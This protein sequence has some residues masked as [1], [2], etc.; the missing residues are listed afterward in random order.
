MC[1]S[2]RESVFL[3]HLIGQLFL[4]P[5][6]ARAPAGAQQVAVNMAQDSDAPKP[7]DK[8]KGKAVDESKDEKPI[9]NG[10]KEEDKKD[11]RLR[12]ACLSDQFVANQAAEVADEELNE[13]DQQLKNELDMMVER[14]TVGVSDATSE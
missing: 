8:G 3:R 13:E 5:F 6:I 1:L 2:P 12:R 11:G 4:R 14:L 9:V 10:K 7:L